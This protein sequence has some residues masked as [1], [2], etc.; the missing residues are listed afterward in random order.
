M[1][2]HVGS[3]RL[4]NG[5]QSAITNSTTNSRY[6][7]LQPPRRFVCASSI[8]QTPCAIFAKPRADYPRSRNLCNFPVSVRSEQQVPPAPAA[9][10]F[11][12]RVVHIADPVRDLCQ[13]ACRLSS[14]PESLQLS[15]FRPI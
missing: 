12:L 8:L 7:P 14:Q 3:T 6:H 13:T 4:K 5:G 15:R 2:I 10:P 1:P 11:R 9:S